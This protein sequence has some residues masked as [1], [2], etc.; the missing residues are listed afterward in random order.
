MFRL[1]S[2]KNKLNHFI[3]RLEA[4]TLAECPHGCPEQEDATHVLLYCQRYNEVR[5]KVE[6][7]LSPLHTPLEATTLLGL[8]NSIPKHTHTNINIFH[9]LLIGNQTT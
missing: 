1:R 5:A 9:F 3:S 6:E 7:K 2:G 8:N 4:E